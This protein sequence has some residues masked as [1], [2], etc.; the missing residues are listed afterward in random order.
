MYGYLRHWEKA[1]LE[2]S[3]TA[4]IFEDKRK[5]INSF[6]C[7]AIYGLGRRPGGWRQLQ[8]WGW[9]L[10]VFYF[11]LTDIQEIWITIQTYKRFWICTNEILNMHK[12]DILNRHNQEILNREVRE[13][14]IKNWRDLEH[15]PY[16]KN[17]E[18]SG[19]LLL[20][21]PAPVCWENFSFSHLG[22]LIL[23]ISRQMS[24]VLTYM[25]AN[26]GSPPIS[27]TG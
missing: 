15:H 21:C 7:M 25:L 9:R 6:G 17:E 27:R 20:S 26:F 4:N 2:Y 11:V 18:L 14:L 13:I 24:S 1:I 10:T 16:C 19:W 5:D 23:S 8:N 22:F 3:I 12:W